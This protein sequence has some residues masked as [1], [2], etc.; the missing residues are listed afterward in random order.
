MVTFTGVSTDGQ[1]FDRT[2]IKF[3]Q[4]LSYQSDCCAQIC[5]SEP[6]L[7]ANHHVIRVGCSVPEHGVH[8]LGTVYVAFTKR[9]IRFYV[10]FLGPVRSKTRYRK[11]VHS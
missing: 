7:Q 8:A 2:R 5:G 4:W 11:Y 9:V 3:L 6:Q 10:F 1:K